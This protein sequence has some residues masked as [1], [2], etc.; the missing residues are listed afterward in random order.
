MGK[1]LDCK[2]AGLDCDVSVCAQTEEEVIPQVGEHIQAIHG[3]KGFSKEFY[4]QARAAIHEGDCESGET[5]APE[6]ECP[7]GVCNL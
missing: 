6:Q 4:D 3:M 2:D 1:K 7:G 5:F